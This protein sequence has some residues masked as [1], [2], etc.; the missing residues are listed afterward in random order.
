[1]RRSSVL[2]SQFPRALLPHL[3]HD[4]FKSPSEDD[5]GNPMKEEFISTPVAVVFPLAFL[6]CLLPSLTFRSALK[7]FCF[8]VLICRAR[9][10]LYVKC[11][12][13]FIILPPSCHLFRTPSPFLLLFWFPIIFSSRL[14]FSSSSPPTS[15][16][17]LPR[18]RI[19]FLLP[20]IRF[21]FPVVSSLYWT[22]Q[23]IC[24]LQPFV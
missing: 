23:R 18:L 8:R 24:V 14:W 9:S 4:K 19:G 7:D 10:P 2:P 20:F 13:C 12:A 11:S 17:D 3:Y 1:L 21:F 5:D 15:G 22:N 16:Y 6:F